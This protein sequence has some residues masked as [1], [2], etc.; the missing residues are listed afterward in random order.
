MAFSLA[1]M[2]CVIYMGSFSPL[3]TTVTF[4]DVKKNKDHCQSTVNK[5]NIRHHGIPQLLV[6][7]VVLPFE[8]QTLENTEGQPKKKLRK[9][10]A[11]QW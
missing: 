8:S 11:W 1:T 9:K 4:K 10:E 5:K 2:L 7:Y 3:H 6:I